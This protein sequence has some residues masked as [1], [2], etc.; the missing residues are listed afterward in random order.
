M[1]DN[2]SKEAKEAAQ[3]VRNYKAV[4]K[5]EQGRSVLLDMAKN[6]NL[7][8]PAPELNPQKLAFKEGQRAVII[9]IFN[10]L[11]MDYTNVLKLFTSDNYD[12]EGEE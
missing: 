6:A 12:D 7:F 10:T 9:A 11:E 5:G 2:P 8:S 3:V 1:N 4:F